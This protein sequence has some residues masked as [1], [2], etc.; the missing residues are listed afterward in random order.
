MKKLLFWF[1]TGILAALACAQ[2]PPTH[3]V[4]GDVEIQPFTSKIFSNTRNLRVLLPPGYREMI[5]RHRRYPVMYMQ[6][7]QN[8]FDKATSAFGQEWQVDETLHRLWA[9]HKIEPMIIVG[10]DNAQEKRGEEYLPYPD[11]NSPQVTHPRAADYARFLL[12]EVMPYVEKHYRVK[13]GPENAGIGGSSYG[14]LVS[15]Y[16]VMHHPGVFGHVLLESMPLHIQHEQLI[17][18]ARNTPQWPLKVFIGIGTHE[19]SSGSDLHVRF[20]RKLAD[21][22]HAQGLKDDRVK[23][24]VTEGAQHNEQAWA[25]RFPQAMEFLWAK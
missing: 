7:G 1:A 19:G 16:F 24:V 5:N 4:S 18:D 20:T 9:E 11:V 12:E 21:V 25:G 3:T 23:L 15:L 2:N 22:L 14:G 6:D 10:I 17:E 8:L 13:R